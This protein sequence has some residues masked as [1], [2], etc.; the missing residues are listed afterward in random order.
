MNRR[1]PLGACCGSM[2]VLGTLT[3]VE[4]RDRVVLLATLR[5][6]L[7]PFDFDFGSRKLIG[8]DEDLIAFFD[9]THVVVLLA[10]GK[11]RLWFSFE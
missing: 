5:E 11:R 8:G 10:S 7:L 9:D 1:E 3:F 2:M 6:V 4:E